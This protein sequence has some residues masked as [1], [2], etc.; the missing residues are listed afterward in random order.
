MAIHPIA[1][2]RP[3]FWEIVVIAL[4]VIVVFGARRLPDLGKTIGTAIRNFQRSIKGED[5]DEQR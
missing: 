3:G 5:A 4:V 2:I 1:F